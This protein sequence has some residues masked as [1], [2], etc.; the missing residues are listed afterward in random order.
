MHI[1]MSI[2]IINAKLRGLN[3][4]NKGECLSTGMDL[5]A[6]DRFMARTL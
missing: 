2:G 3:P 4:V 1:C 6:K 5:S